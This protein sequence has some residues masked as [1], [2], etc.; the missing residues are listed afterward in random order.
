MRLVYKI[1]TSSYVSLLK[2]V[3]PFNE[4]AKKW[5]E[6]RIDSLDILSKLELKGNVIWF[7]CASLG[8]FEQGKPVMESYMKKNAEW[9]LV[10]T[11][12]SPSGYEARFNYE[13]ADLVLYLP[14]EKKEYIN[15][16]LDKVNPKIAVFVKYEFWFEY[17][18]ELNQ[19]SIPMVFISS[20]FRANQLFFKWFGT[21]FLEQL[22]PVNFFFVQEE[23]SKELLERNHIKQVKVSGD[24]RFD[25]VLETYK[26]SESFPLL[27]QFK[28][29]SQI[30][31]FGSAW[32]VETEISINLINKLPDGWKV[33]YA[34]HEINTEEILKYKSKIS[35]SSVLFSQLSEKSNLDSKVLIVDTIG[36][37]ARIYKY[38][39]VAV[40]GGGFIDGIHNILEP[41]VFGA[42]VFFGPNHHK[43]WEAN[44]AIENEVGFEFK[45]QED[46]HEKLMPI[47]NHE[48]NLDKKSASSRGFVK[49]RVGAT[50]VILKHLLK[51]S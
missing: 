12:F 1:A 8:E 7:H 9:K 13:L 51:L 47:L 18:R 10:V 35:E 43:F 50:K 34:P 31:V 48:I 45:N 14:I 49:N 30:I 32:S 26:K 46:L 15:L 6:G 41:L 21:W 33:I 2:I 4:R 36:H 22:K 17:M 39:D 42:P 37:L 3:S 11:F 5:L 44:L 27:E 25:R 40:V 24:T 19:R 29:D 23:K 38:A 16:F 28:K 20:T